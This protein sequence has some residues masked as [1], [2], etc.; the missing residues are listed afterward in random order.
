MKVRCHV[1]SIRILLRT[2][3]GCSLTVTSLF[4]PN[5]SR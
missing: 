5:G 3:F 2:V 4:W 1:S